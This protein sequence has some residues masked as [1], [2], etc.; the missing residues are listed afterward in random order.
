[1]KALVLAA[2]FGTRLAPYTDRL[3][4]AL[5]PVG[6]T[7]LLGRTIT[8]LKAAGCTAIAVNTHHLARA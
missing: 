1:M 4:K 8:A 3:P 7:P 2:G 5:F 6:G